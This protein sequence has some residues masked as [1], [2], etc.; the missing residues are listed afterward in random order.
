MSST[1]QIQNDCST[2]SRLELVLI[3]L[4]KLGAPGKAY[5]DSLLLD[6]VDSVF[7]ALS[8]SNRQALYS[9]LKSVFGVRREAIPVDLEGFVASLECMFGDGA[10]LVEAKMLQALHG[11]VPAF[12]LS[13]KQGELSFLRY[14]KIRAVKR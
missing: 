13:Q 10:F 1:T 9:H 3:E 14:L 4:N 5:F 2:E 12:R 8:G 7:S 11:K 6:A